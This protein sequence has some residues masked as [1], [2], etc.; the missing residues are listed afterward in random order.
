MVWAALSVGGTDCW[1]GPCW[2]RG[3]FS[4]R[5]L[6]FTGTRAVLEVMAGSD[7]LKAWAGREGP[8]KSRVVSVCA[9]VA[10]F[11]SCRHWPARVLRKL[12]RC[13]GLCI[14]LGSEST[15]NVCMWCSCKRFHTCNA[16]SWHF[17]SRPCGSLWAHWL[18]AVRVAGYQSW[19]TREEKKWRRN[20]YVCSSQAWKESGNPGVW[21]LLFSVLV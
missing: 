13:S 5:P 19:D 10:L 16:K 17:M 11:T 3:I 1:L 18:L 12:L 21:L 2:T 20:S 4:F 8:D 9:Y 7:P 14:A 15:L 6:C